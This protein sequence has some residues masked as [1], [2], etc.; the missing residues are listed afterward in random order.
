MTKREHSEDLLAVCEENIADCEREIAAIGVPHTD[1]D[2]FSLRGFTEA[3]AILKELRE[4]LRASLE[5][6]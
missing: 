3:L 1:G 4:E 2:R 6:A 5:A